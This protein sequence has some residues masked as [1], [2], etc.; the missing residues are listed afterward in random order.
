MKQ[1][2]NTASLF[3]RL[4]IILVETSRPGNIGAVAR[5]MKTMGKALLSGKS[6]GYRLSCHQVSHVQKMHKKV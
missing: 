2:Q 1:P 5:A 6:D 4:R 3:H